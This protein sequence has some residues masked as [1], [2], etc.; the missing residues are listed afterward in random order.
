MNLARGFL[1]AGTQ[2]GVGK[3]TISTGIMG[4]LKKRGRSVKPFKVGPDYIDPQFHR[5]ITQNP[6]RNLDAHLLEEDIIKDLF[7]KN[8][9]PED[10]AVVEGVMGL[11]DGMGTQKDE[12]SSAHIS[13]ILNLP[14][15]LVING[16][17]MSSSA[18][19]MVLG[20]KNYDPEVDI[21][22]VI[23][24]NLSGQ[25]H[26]ELL[27]EAI[28]RDT[29]ISCVGY[30]KKNT[31]IKLESRH[32]GLIPCGEV[33][34]LDKKIQEIVEMVEET[35]DIDKLIQLSRNIEIKE[36]PDKTPISPDK[37]IK[38]AY[39]YDD[40]FNFYYEDNLDLLKDLG[41]DLIP[42]SPLKDKSL[43]KDINGIY[44]GGGFPEVFGKELEKNHE[45]RGAILEK[46]KSGLPI[47]AECG[48]FMYLTKDI[49]DIEGHTYSMVGVFDGR[50][51]MTK[52]L[53]NFGYCQIETQE[54]SRFFKEKLTIKSHEFHRSMVEIEDADY[55]YQVYKKRNG[56][57]IKTWGC[58]IEKH[59]TLGAFPH[60][61]FYSNLEFVKGFI[62]RC[63]EYKRV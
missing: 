63:R 30:L 40:A 3:T 28:E 59:N 56:K 54:N 46:A 53:Q 6:S 52:R 20:Y 21:V 51:K 14:V 16:G 5:Y 7:H 37:R 4:A 17:G 22:G 9:I 34:V 29:G 25:S 50:G 39:A 44:I 38:I 33:P 18:A 61:H 47:Y 55:I 24:N 32:L 2:S 43:P 48:G 60:I 27:K 1:L 35:I 42:F 26:Y 36:I 45:I 19:A 15:I 41:C 57:V 10:I 11:Y 12:G 58:G 13:K 31:D 8:L 23:I 49:Q 62:D